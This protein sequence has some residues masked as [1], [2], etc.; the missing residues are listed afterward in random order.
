MFFSLLFLSNGCNLSGGCVSA[1][2]TRWPFRTQT[3]G[4]LKKNAAFLTFPVE[5]CKNTVL[6]V[7]FSE[8]LSP[9]TQSC[10][11][12]LWG[13]GLFMGCAGE[14]AQ[15][16]PD[17]WHT[18]QQAAMTGLAAGSCRALH[19]ES[20]LDNRLMIAGDID[21]WQWNSCETAVKANKNPD[22]FCLAS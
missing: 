12:S 18:L 9:S 2:P 7:S 10:C 20:A 17:V 3:A 16:G 13:H 22:F 14:M 15:S 6:T 5:F 8:S 11:R 21:E 1:E 4:K 19:S